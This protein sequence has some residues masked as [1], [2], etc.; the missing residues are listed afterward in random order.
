MRSL[1]RRRLFWLMMEPGPDHGVGGARMEQKRVV[2]MSPAS[3]TDEDTDIAG[4]GVTGHIDL[5]D[6]TGLVL[7]GPGG[8]VTDLKR[9]TG[10]ARSEKKGEDGDA[11]GGK[12]KKKAGPTTVATEARTAIDQPRSD[13]CFASPGSNRGEYDRRFCDVSSQGCS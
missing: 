11:E 4:R 7:V 3:G 6:R 13:S 1:S 2:Q 5:R 8:L 12:D 10:A 9:R